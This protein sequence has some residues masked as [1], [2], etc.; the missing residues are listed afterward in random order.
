MGFGEGTNMMLSL[1]KSGMN[2]A[3]KH[4]VTSFYLCVY[5]WPFP[6]SFLFTLFMSFSVL[7]FLK[8]TKEAGSNS[9]SHSV[10]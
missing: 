1:K 5:L 3:E 8:N 4:T 9:C 10:L 7:C 6:R 2:D